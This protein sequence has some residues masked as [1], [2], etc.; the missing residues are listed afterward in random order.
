MKNLLLFISLSIGAISYGQIFSEVNASHL[1]NV[2]TRHIIPN[3]YKIYE[4]APIKLENTLPKTI[5]KSEK[6]II[7]IPFPNGQFIAF[8]IEYSPVL[9]PKLGSKYPK[10]K[11]FSGENKELGMNLKITYH[12]DYGFH[13]TVMGLTKTVYIDP[14]SF[15]NNTHIISYYKKD[16][17]NSEKQNFS[18]GKPIR[19][20]DYENYLTFK[21]KN[22]VLKS[23]TNSGELLRT[24]RIA[25]ACTQQYYNFHG[26]NT[27][28]ALA[29]MATTLNRVNQVY[30]NE[31][32]VRMIMVDN[33][34]SLI[35][36]SVAY[37][38]S[39]N[40][41][42]LLLNQS[43][44]VIDSI[45]G[46][47]NYDV[48]HTFS[49][50]AGGLASLGVPCRNA[51]KAKGV[52]GTNSPIG[53]P[54][55]IDYVAHEIGHQFGANHTFNGTSGSCA[56]NRNEDTAFEPG[57]GS[58]I[59][60]Y[61]GICSGQNLQSNS[62]AYFHNA[63]FDEI[64]YYV[65]N[66]YG[67]ECATI[68]E[69]GN[70]PPLTNIIT[71]LRTIPIYTPFKLEGMS[72]DLDGDS[73]SYC[74]E[75]VDIG[76]AGNPDIPIGNA[77]ILRSFAPTPE[78][79]RIFPK[80][81]T[82]LSNNQIIGERVPEYQ[83]DLHF[84][85]TT[86][87][88]SSNGGGVSYASTT[89][90]VTEQG[91]PFEVLFPNGEE[92]LSINSPIEVSWE[93]ANTDDGPIDCQNVNISLLHKSSNIWHETLLVENIPNSGGAMII[94]PDIDS[95]IGTMNRLKIEAADN[96]F[97]DISDQNFYITALENI[98]LSSKSYHVF[99]N[100]N[101]GRFTIDFKDLDLKNVTI[102][103]KNVTGHI[104]FNKLI[105]TTKT[106][107]QKLDV[108]FLNKGIYLLELDQEHLKK[109]SL[110]SIQ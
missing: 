69:T 53:D 24:Y 82:I 1:K 8:D 12:E 93:V 107:Q 96:I 65:T 10:I 103:I 90:Y 89:V 44:V 4:Y 54:Y 91:G 57:S 105:K 25:I 106:S 3:N 37:N 2:S 22:P 42:N 39:N 17:I 40:N 46:T 33:N 78:P 47:D 31:V 43:Q 60:A 45:I 95:L 109:V 66:G 92:Y 29:A 23:Q 18:E 56:G 52:T 68:S 80:M 71:D 63:S 9:S 97:F 16:Y 58:T 99:P 110:I 15:Q 55:D 81:S 62:D 30:E 36:F 19:S 26:A 104:V 83:R 84:R 88:N 67:S 13:A 74:W 35:D 14:Y 87:D 7:E 59:M 21:N 64:Y 76:M 49:T 77:P 32:S 79:T 73:L 11:T 50:G 51:S 38:M 20:L 72:T 94:I 28:S 6:T 41:T 101:S 98:E 108:S 75:Q 85:L 100:P 5:S 70:T 48:G 86:R 27:E 102:N 61:A 34:D